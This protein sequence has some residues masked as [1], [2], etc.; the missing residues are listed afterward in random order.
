[1]S[2]QAFRYTQSSLIAVIG[3]LVACVGLSAGQ[4]GADGLR[5]PSER[6]PR[7][8]AA[9]PVKFPPYE[10]RTMANGLQVVVVSQ[11]EQPVVSARMLVR[12]GAAQDPKGKE[13]L[14][15]LTAA[16]L[17]QGTATRSAAQIAEEIDFMGGLMGTG[18]GTDL[19]FVNAVS[20]RDGLGQVLDLMA[21]VVLKPAFSPDEIERQTAQAVSSLKVSADDPDTVASQVIDR[22]IFGFHPYG[23]PSGGTSESLAALTQQDFVDFHKTWFVPNNALIAL[24]GDVTPDEAFTQV[25]RVFGGW[26]KGPVPAYLPMEPPPA[27]RRL[28]VID[29]PGSVQ[30]EIR[31][32]NLAIARR[33]ADHLALD[34]AV[35][36]LGGEG[37]NRLQ[38]VL[39]SQ[40]S[41]TYGA[42]ADLD[43]YKFAGAVV[44]ETDTRTEA[45]IE[46]LRTVV[47]EFARLQRERVYTGELEGAQDFL[48]GSFP[49]SIES[50]DAIATRVLNQLFYELPLADLPAYPE[51]VRT[52]TVD[53]IQRVARAWLKP[54][55]LSVVL[56]GDAEKFMSGL[57]GAGFTNIE[58]IPIAELDL[59]NA[60]L[61]R[62]RPGAQQ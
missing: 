22:L 53:D 32:G 52:V 46:A 20:M 24:V 37:G 55:Q 42:S 30:T 41:L 31:A 40:K 3:V 8:L 2:R 26:A 35:K 10:I 23:M 47:D 18:A 13:G 58:R 16:L 54:A 21:D 45:T 7:P 33:N 9:K 19:S 6:P 14:A 4:G 43:A 34:Q 28:V 61:R 25:E 11:N 12:A 62:A 44:A 60:D 29:K 56:V 57:A 38:Q 51:L 5:W 48:A 50:P 15:M 49:L 27:V 36:I 59:T 17:D 1:M 39:R